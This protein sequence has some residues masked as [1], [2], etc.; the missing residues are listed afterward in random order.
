MRKRERI[1]YAEAQLIVQSLGITSI[2]EYKARYKEGSGLPY[3]PPRTYKCE[4]AGWEGFLPRAPLAFLS[5]AEAQQ[6]VKQ[7]DITSPKMYNTRYKE[8]P[9]LPSNPYRVYLE[10]WIGW[11]VFLGR[12]APVSLLSYAEA[13]QHLQQLSIASFKEYR[14]RYRDYPGLPSHP[15]I[16]YK[17]EWAGWP[18]FFNKK[19]PE[20]FLSYVEAQKRVQQLGITSSREYRIRYREHPSLPYEPE[21][22]YRAEWSGWTAFLPKAPSAFLS[23]SEAQQRVQQLGITSS[24]IFSSRYKEC[25]GLPATPQK[26]YKSEWTGWTKFL[27]KAPS[28]FLS[29]SEAQQCVRQLGIT[30][31]KRYQARYK[32]CLGLPSNPDAI[33]QREWTGWAAFL[34]KK[35]PEAF[36]SYVEA[37]KRVQQLGITSVREYHACYKEF[38]GLPTNPKR[39]YQGEWTGWATFLAR[40]APVAFL[41]YAEAKLCLKQLGITSYKEY[42]ARYKECPGLPSRPD[43]IYKDEKDGSVFFGKK[44]TAK[45]LNY[46]EAKQLVQQ[47]CMTSAKEYKT[48]YKHHPGL[49]ADPLVYYKKDWRGWEL[50]L[51]PKEIKTL[52]SLELACKVLQIK[53]SKQYRQTR[54]KF[55]QLPSHPERLDGWKD[56]YDLLDISRP[57]PFAQLKELVS[58]AKLKTLLDYQKWRVA[59]AD[60]RVPARPVE[61]YAGKGWTNAYDFLGRVRPFKVRYLEPKWMI[62]GK[63]IREFLKIARGG[64]SK[65]KNLCEFVRE[66]II[67]CGFERDPHLFLTRSKTNIQPMLDLLD[68]VSI[69]RK[70]SWLF[71]INEFLDWIIKNTLTVEDEETGE[72]SQINGAINPFQQINFN[73]EATTPVFNET[74]KPSLPYQFVLAGR[75]W[76]FPLDAIERQSS[77]RDLVH[78]Q[79]FSADWVALDESSEIDRED[80]DC[81]VKESNGKRYLWLPIYWT[82]TYALMQLPARGR[83]I[84]YCDSGEADREIPDFENGKVVWCQNKSNMAG[85]TKSQSMIHRTSD[86]DIGVHYTTNK[87]SFNGEG[88]TIPFMPVELAYWLIKLRKWQQRF[89]KVERPLPWMECTKTKLNEIQKKQKGRNCFLFR[90]FGQEEPGIFG[91]R[92]A[93]RLAASLFFSTRE[94]L[95]LAKYNNMKF[96]QFQSLNLIEPSLSNFQSDFTPHSM[97]VSLINAYIYEFGL[98]IEIILKLVGHSSIVMTIYY[99]KSGLGGLN[100]REKLQRG[101]KQAA[102]VAAETLRQFVEQKRIEECHGELVANNEEFLKFINND[103]PVAAYQWKDYGFCP[104]GGNFCKE[105]GEPVAVKSSIYHPVPAGYLGEQNCLQCRFF[106]TG[107]AFMV[108]LVSLFNEI[109]HN[110]STQCRRFNNLQSQVQELTTRIE[111]ISHKQ[112]SEKRITEHYDQLTAEKASLQ[113]KR[114]LVNS[115]LETRSKKIDPLL[116]DMNAIH[117]LIR[118]CKLV[119]EKGKLS[120]NDSYQLIVPSDLSMDVS[121]EDNSWFYQLTEVCENAELFRSCSDDLALAPRSQAIDRLLQFNDMQPQMMFLSEEEQLIV[122]NQITQL[123]LTRLKSWNK[124]D[125]LMDNELS[126]KDLPEEERLKAADIKRLFASAETI[127]LK[128]V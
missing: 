30:S 127:K 25:A 53:D 91:S 41:S 78:L 36:L 69:A 15:D 103:R 66:Y 106:V 7:L 54:K 92:L 119:I 44:S 37:Q 117:R 82:Y 61:V 96:K 33:Y 114:R 32:E 19:V 57:Y 111:V 47:L 71:S 16:F 64:E 42:Q 73:E 98:P 40:K 115:E 107:P 50:F 43:I 83:Q 52:I 39:T 20:A 34:D 116:I 113:E 56:Y 26:V 74:N 126:F 93:Q 118:E 49:P 102:S 11:T 29:Y 2:K 67:K 70:K 79:K 59:F 24:K 100:V 123:L 86:N 8:C 85:Q 80:P 95:S 76:I 18:A 3:N 21:K 23:Y 12:I 84:I 62:W 63:S 112:Y 120:E 81:V 109:S 46:A 51:I 99:V 5:Y 97:R 128:E 9:G 87:T 48:C 125:R 110:V 58:D 77:Y 89:N 14:R 6:R 38:S 121:I 124:L 28:V 75:D 65:E 108:G 104:V 4:W 88:Y 35:V 10:E 122:G 101:E 90:D 22:K 72:V 13:Q 94:E 1:G 55:K 27:P 17:G 105:G 68:G 60:P 45:Y 31:S